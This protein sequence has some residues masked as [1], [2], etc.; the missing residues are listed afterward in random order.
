MSRPVSEEAIARRVLP[1]HIKCAKCGETKPATEFHVIR[2]EATGR[3]SRCKDCRGRAQA[4]PDLPALAG[5]EWRPV[6]GYEGI[7]VVSN[8]GRV[9]A[10]GK[11]R[12]ARYRHNMAATLDTKGYVRCRLSLPGKGKRECEVHRLV[13]AAFVG[14][15]PEGMCSRHLNGIR[16][17]CRLENLQ[18]GTPQENMDDRT[19]HGRTRRGSQAG[20]AKLTEEQVADI[21]KAAASGAPLVALARTAGVA[22]T[23][24][25]AIVSGRTWRHVPLVGSP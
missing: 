20:R 3:A 19:I 4:R 5:E 24:I 7:Y 8:L 23:T 18:Y 13:L 14:P 9:Q 2:R 6:V 12:F 22:P 21:R 11:G 16:S 17:D 10:V 15:C 25:H 1:T